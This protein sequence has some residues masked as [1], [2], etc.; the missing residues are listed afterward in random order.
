MELT[1]S[2]QTE[3]SG[4]NGSQYHPIYSTGMHPQQAL[5]NSVSLRRS[6]TDLGAPLLG[7]NPTHVQMPL[8]SGLGVYTT[9]PAVGFDSP[10]H[11]HLA[12]MDNRSIA[13]LPHQL[14]LAVQPPQDPHHPFRHLSYL[15]QTTESRGPKKERRQEHKRRH[16]ERRHRAA[17]HETNPKPTTHLPRDI[18]AIGALTTAMSTA[19]IDGAPE[20]GTL[21]GQ[22]MRRGNPETAT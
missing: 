8:M 20:R 7:P 13:R 9:E 1:H 17:V 12:D 21:N 10:S 22:P 11:D 5:T 2:S 18:G 14:D 19:S 3:I 6:T 16:S 4:Q 15:S